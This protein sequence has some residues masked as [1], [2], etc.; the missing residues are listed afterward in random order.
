M[1]NQKI[2]AIWNTTIEMANERVMKADP[3][4]KSP[5]KKNWRDNFIEYTSR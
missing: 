2:P 1:V 5:S 4:D 3:T